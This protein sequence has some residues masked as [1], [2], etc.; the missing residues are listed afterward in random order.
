MFSKLVTELFLFLNN[1]EFVLLSVQSNQVDYVANDLIISVQLDD[2]GY[3]IDVLFISNAGDKLCITLQDLLDYFNISDVR[4]TYQIRDLSES[5]MYKGIEYLAM[6]TSVVMQLQEFNSMLIECVHS[7]IS[8]RRANMLKEY[9][10]NV[11]MQAADIAW[12]N[13]SYGE[14]KFLYEKHIE[15][16][17]KTQASRLKYI[18][19]HALC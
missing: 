5:E 17:S 16:L 6:N 14:A 9:N 11:D 15:Y 1:C 18:I 19:E 2:I 10:Y 13:K 4:G 12:K 8:I 7:F 3:Q